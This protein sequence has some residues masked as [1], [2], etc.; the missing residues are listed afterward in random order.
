MPK[1]FSAQSIVNYSPRKS[2]L[3]TNAIVGLSVDEAL[4]QLSFMNKG[5]VKK[6]S[7][8]I[9]N[10]VNNLALSQEEY[11]NYFI[12]T[13]IAEEAYTYYRI[14]PRAR[15][16]AFRIRKRY[17]RLKIELDKKLTNSNLKS[18]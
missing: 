18:K 8:L 11:S 10:A 3:I 17:S 15:G 6:F 1:K 16:S 4:T 12:K 14:E 2:R 7:N 13:M 5:K 9:K